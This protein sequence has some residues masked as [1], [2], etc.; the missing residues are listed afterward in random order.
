[1]FGLKPDDLER[2][3]DPDQRL[4]QLPIV[5]KAD[6]ESAGRPRPVCSV[7]SAMLRDL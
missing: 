5:W 7:R 6:R 4:P 2:R 3:G 1:M